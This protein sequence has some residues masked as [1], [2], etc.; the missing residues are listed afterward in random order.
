MGNL[1]DTSPTHI[2]FEKLYHPL[3][4]CYYNTYNMAGNIDPSRIL[5]YK[6]ITY[7]TSIRNTFKLIKRTYLNIKNIIKYKP[8]LVITLHDYQ[9]MAL[10]PTI[11][12][13]KIL[14]TLHCISQKPLF[15]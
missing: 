13:I 10:L 9:L 3:F 2:C 4:I 1:T 11:I 6:E 7:N 8:D 15:L 5:E 14:Y 12:S